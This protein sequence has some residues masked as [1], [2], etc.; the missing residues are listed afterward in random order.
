MK[1]RM[2]LVMILTLG[3]GALAG[4][5]ELASWQTEKGQPP[6]A[7]KTPVAATTDPNYLIGPED[8]I[9]I[10]V[11]KEPEMS[12]TVPVRPDGKISLPLLNDVQAAGLTPVQLADSLTERVKKYLEEPR[13][14][15]I[16]SAVNSRRIYLTGQIARPGAMPLL[17]DMTIMQALATAGCC[18]EFANTKKIYLLRNE[19]GKQV[20]YPFNYNNALKGKDTEQNLVLKPGDTIVVP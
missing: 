5:Q 10:N 1:G 6:V 12:A 2:C 9:N 19:N 18:L 11:W 15:V 17:T 3:L 4:A 7:S 20:K 16:V 8:V 13:V 14:T